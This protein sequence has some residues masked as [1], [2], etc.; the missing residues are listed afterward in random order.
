MLGEWITV[1]DAAAIVGCSRNTITRHVE[2]GQI[3]RRHP[4]GRKTPTLN[5]ES[6]EEFAV[7]RRSKLADDEARRVERRQRARPP[8]DG[9]DWLSCPEA[10]AAMG[11]SPQY[12]GRLAN[13]G[14]MAATRRGA[15]WYF[16][17]KDLGRPD[18]DESV[19]TVRYRGH[20][21]AG[22]PAFHA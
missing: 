17:R 1:A 8:D 9:H 11:V 12:L 21:D 6:V 14:R 10:A 2:A 3:A 7:W 18:A 16:R 15:R 5:R 4:L 20:G 13:Q 19:I 22:W